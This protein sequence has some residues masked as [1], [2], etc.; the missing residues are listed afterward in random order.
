MEEK[1]KKRDSSLDLVRIVGLLLVL[2]VHFMARL[3][4]NHIPMSGTVP[5]IMCLMRTVFMACVPI[6]LVLSGY[7]MNRKTYGKGYY[8]NLIH[9]L[10]IYILASVV[11]VLDLKYRMEPISLKQAILGLFNYSD[12]PYAWY[13][14]M[15]IGLYLILP[16]INMGYHGMETRKKKTILLLSLILVTSLPQITNIFDVTSEGWKQNL[17][18]ATGSHTQNPCY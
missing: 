15:Y 17:L 5:Y 18:T 13:L 6:F 4:F 9:T 10:G 1:L 11:S 8:K 14:E 7:L 3:N 16:L 2:S 12:A